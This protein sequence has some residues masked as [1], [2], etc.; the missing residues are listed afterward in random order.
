MR[1]KVSGDSEQGLIILRLGF[2]FKP[3]LARHFHLSQQT[4]ARIFLNGFH[5]PEIKRL[6][7]ID[8]IRVAASAPQA[9]TADGFVHPTAQCPGPIHVKPAAFS[10]NAH[11]CAE[12]R[13][14]FDLHQGLTAFYEHAFFN[15]E[16]IW[17]E[18][19]HRGDK[20]VRPAGFNIV[21]LDSSQGEVGGGLEINW[22]DVR[23]EF[24]GCVVADN[25]LRAQTLYQRGHDAP[26]DGRYHMHPI[27]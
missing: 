18:I 12:N 20:R 2:K 9:H 4:Q 17:F 26:V 15:D 19:A 7:H 21:S 5:T 13:L 8:F 23:K 1:G 22:L 6:A 25:E 14:R 11:V 10:A 27:G 3:G 24:F 16:L